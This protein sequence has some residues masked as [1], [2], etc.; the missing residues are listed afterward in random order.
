MSIDV[1]EKACE[2][3]RQEILRNFDVSFYDRDLAK[4]REIIELLESIKDDLV[5]LD[6]L[7]LYEQDALEN[8]R[9]IEIHIMVIRLY[10]SYYYCI[11][12][13][14]LLFVN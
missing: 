14:F 2:L 13:A 5:S 11:F 9:Y 6:L 8:I 3:K 7:R 10:F 4:A 12:I 1:Y